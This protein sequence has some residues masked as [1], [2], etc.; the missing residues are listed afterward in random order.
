MRLS[1][2]CVAKPTFRQCS[3]FL[4]GLVLILTMVV[5]PLPAGA[6]GCVSTVTGGASAS[7]RFAPIAWGD[8]IGVAAPAPTITGFTP[9]SGSDGTTVVIRGTGFVSAS[10]VSFNGK[11]T[12][13]SCDSSSQITSNVPAGA[14][15]GRIT[16]ANAAGTAVSTASF[17]VTATPEVTGF[18]PTSGPA[19]AKVLVVGRGF[20]GTTAVTFN[21]TAASF[22]PIS[23][24]QIS[25]IVPAGA[26]SGKIAVTT[27]GGKSTS[28]GSFTVVLAPTVASFT[29]DAGPVGTGVTITGTGLAGATKV[30]FNGKTAAFGVVSATRITATVPVGATGGRIAVTTPAGVA[31]S[32]STFTVSVAPSITSF[33]PI[34]GPVR[35]V[36][37]LAGTGFTGAT[38]VTFNGTSGSFTVRSST[39][40]FVTV[41]TSATSGKIAVT[42]LGGTA[43]SAAR[44]TVTPAPSVSSFTPTSGPVGTNVTISGQGFTGTTAVTFNG[45]EA[46]FRVVGSTRITATVPAGATSGR[47][48]VTNPGG[49]GTSATSFTVIGAPTITS[50]APSSGPVGTKVT[51]T[52]TRFTGATAVTINGI[53][54]SVFSVVS[55]TQVSATVPSGATSGPIAVTTPGGTGTSAAGF[56]VIPAPTVSFFTPASGPAGTVVTIVGS[57]LGEAFAVRFS[58]LGASFTQVSA[59]QITA[60]VPYGASSGPI[61]VTTRG[62]VGTSASSFTVIPTPSITRLNRA[63]GKRGGIVAIGGTGFGDSRGTG[64]VRFGSKSCTAYIS[65]SDTKISCRV[66]ATASYR[67]VKVTVTTAGGTSN[68]VVFTVKR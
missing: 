26:T 14:T 54:A 46:N 65:W 30:T 40:I 15:S 29:P 62:G 47:I 9:T 6:A 32:S 17:T 61:T 12:G 41:P 52:G 66:P 39:Q 27:R 2:K 49:K 22:S 8:G 64:S 67:R 25:T 36:V 16:V 51:V 63:S 23:P 42:G 35:T 56:T 59:T 3:P 7:A 11:P 18:S 28:A 31:T 21:G 19:G 20:T 53:K 68:A 33:V 60:T 13:F 55:A 43:T 37:T 45:T 4:L 5:L 57:A 10:R 44:Y 50:F 38:K 1:E 48:A 58:N 34:E 24:T